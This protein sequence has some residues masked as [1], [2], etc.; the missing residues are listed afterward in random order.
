MNLVERFFRDLSQDAILPGSFS[1]VAQLV[2]RIWA[3]LAERN[4]NP[5]R[6]VC[7]ARG[8]EILEK[9]QRAEA[10]LARASGL[11]VGTPGTLH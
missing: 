3:Y 4:L 11:T 10:A 1:S 9:I 8:Q 5:T 2:E 6:Y 7:R